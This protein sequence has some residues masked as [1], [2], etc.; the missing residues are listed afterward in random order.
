MIVAFAPE[1][2]GPFT[3]AFAPEEPMPEL[4]LPFTLWAEAAEAAATTSAA[5]S[6]IAIDLM[7]CSIF[8]TLR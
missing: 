7:K 4:T 6:P 8:W 3:P 1:W 2:A 5:E